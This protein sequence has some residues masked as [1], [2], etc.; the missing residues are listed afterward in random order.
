MAEFHKQV[1]HDAVEDLEMESFRR[2]IDNDWGK[3]LSPLWSRYYAAR[4]AL[5]EAV[6][7]EAIAE[8]ELR[9]EKE[10]ANVPSD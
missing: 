4:D 8:T 3:D 6:R 2:G 7:E 1:L 10:K 9:M 5:I